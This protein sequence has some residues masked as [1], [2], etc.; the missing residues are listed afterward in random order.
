MLESLQLLQ[1]VAC[2][3][4]MQQLHLK[5]R[6][7]LENCPWWRT[8]VPP[9]AC[10]TETLTLTLRWFLTLTFN[11]LRTW[12]RPIHTQKVKV[13]GSDGSKYK[14]ETNRR[15]GVIPLPWS[16]NITTMTLQVR[17]SFCKLLPVF[18]ARGYAKRGICRRRV[19]V[20][21]CVCHTPVLYQNG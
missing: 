8:E 12:L 18:T 16:L 2:K 10:R 14:V 21:V 19:S 13:M 1:R 17:G 11:P 6:L 15:T 3:S 4:C 9:T 20:C 5:P 7:K